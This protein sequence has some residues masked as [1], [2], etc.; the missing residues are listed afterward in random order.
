MYAQGKLQIG[1]AIVA[2]V[3]A[4][5]LA[6]CALVRGAS[7]VE[8]DQGAAGQTIAL[9]RGR[10]LIVALESNPTTGYRWEM[11][12]AEGACVEQVGEADFRSESNRVGSGGIERLTF[13]AVRAGEMDLKLVYRR[14]WE[15]GV[16][17]IETFTLHVVVK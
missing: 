5:L 2:L 1:K 3:G 11:E 17:P 6:G 9:A 15:T 8:V 16:A 7:P 4:L 14:S 12:P 10:K 13:Q